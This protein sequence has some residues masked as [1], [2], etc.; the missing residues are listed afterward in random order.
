MKIWFQ[1]YILCLKS[2]L[3]IVWPLQIFFE[4]S[5][6]EI[7]SKIQTI[8]SS[9][10]LTPL[11]I[12][13]PISVSLGLL[14]N[15]SSILAILSGN[16]L[17]P[18]PALQSPIKVVKFIRHHLSFL[19]RESL[20]MYGKI[21]SW[22]FLFLVPGLVKLVQFYFVP[23]VVALDPLYSQGKQ[24]ALKHSQRLAKGQMWKLGLLSITFSLLIPLLLSSNIVTGK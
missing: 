17:I 20:R 11:A 10:Q 9:G 4:W 15:T 18:A 14:I 2:S 23:F 21:L 16:S 19:M 22:S 13:I 1:Q 7:S 6:Q 24:D 5:D 12:W 3:I 8:I